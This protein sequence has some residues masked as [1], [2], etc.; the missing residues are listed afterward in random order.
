MEFRNAPDG[1]DAGAYLAFDQ[2]ED[3][4]SPGTY[5]IGQVRGKK[6]LIFTS[7]DGNVTYQHTRNE[8]QPN[9]NLDTWQFRYGGQVLIRF[10]YDIEFSTNIR[11]HSRRGYND[12]SMNTNELIWNGQLSKT[13]LRSKTLVVA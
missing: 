4:V 7:N 8:L 10:P 11:E 12:P 5:E 2:Q 1:K 3:S 9:A 6:A 13:F